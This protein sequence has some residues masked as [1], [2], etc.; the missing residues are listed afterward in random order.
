LKEQNDSL[1]RAAA[2]K[3]TQMNQMV[4]T[5]NDIE[6]TLRVIKDKEQIIALK[7]R[8]GETGADAAKQINEDIRLIYDLMV[9]NKERIEALEKQLKR[10]G[11]ETSRLNKLVA[12]LNEE[13]KQK[14]I[15]IRQLN[16]LL[17]NKNSE[18]DDLN[19]MLADI[20]IELDSMKSAH[21][22]TIS[23]LE[24][25]RD[26]MYTAYYA[27]GSKSELKD[28]KILN[29]DGFLF[30]GKTELL[31]DNFDK[32]YF[33]KIDIR[34]TDSIELFQ[35]NIKILTSHP[36]GSFNMNE[37]NAGNKV[38]VINN[39]DDFW[40]VSKYLVIEAK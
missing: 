29:R 8:K 26:D 5:I 31:K 1:A 12:G 16:E 14:N 30:F 24:S 33:A 9:Q 21:E 2:Q 32:D 22:E 19:Y 38:L 20:E 37:S 17:K 36:E 23:T 15:E 25:T 35:P 6:A 3:D 13:L 40:S 18:I 27:I 7:A 28:K 11:I 10:S 4:N 39:K 34:K